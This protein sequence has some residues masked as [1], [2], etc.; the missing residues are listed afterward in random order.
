LFQEKPCTPSSGTLCRGARFASCLAPI[1]LSL[2]GVTLCTVVSQLVGGAR[3]RKLSSH[4]FWPRDLSDTVW[5]SGAV[6]KI[7]GG[8]FSPTPRH[9]GSPPNGGGLVHPTVDQCR[10]K[11][12]FCLSL[13]K[14]S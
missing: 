11:F 13:A 12:D 8:G 7:G 1:D 4:G 14:G 9:G 3:S 2:S 5:R 10:A 6:S